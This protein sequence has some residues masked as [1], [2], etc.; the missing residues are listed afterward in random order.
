MTLRY[1]GL[2]RLLNHDCGGGKGGARDAGKTLGDRARKDK[3]S[4]PEPGEEHFAEG[5][6]VKDASAAIQ[7]LK[8][9]W[10]KTAMMK[11]A[12]VIIL[13]NPGA[14]A[15][16]PV[17]QGK[18]ALDGECHAQRELM[19]GCY[20]RERSV[21]RAAGRC[22]DVKPSIVDSDTHEPKRA[23]L[24]QIAREEISG[25]LDPNLGA[26]LKQRLSD[27]AKRTLEPGRDQDLVGGTCDIPCDPQIARDCAPQGLVAHDIVQIG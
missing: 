17:E 25:I 18:P 15:I 20:E 27:Q 13:H 24:Q 5:P 26:G 9:R 3:I 21:R 4:K 8:R 19:G 10:G 22:R 23:L 2:H 7:A 11:L 6:G 1:E 16:G 12:V 14:L